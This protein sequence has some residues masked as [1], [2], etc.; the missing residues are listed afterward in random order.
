[1]RTQ[2]EYRREVVERSDVVA[3][4]NLLGDDGWQLVHAEPVTIKLYKDRSVFKLE[5]FLMREKE[6]HIDPD[7]VLG[8]GSAGDPI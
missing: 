2:Y 8:V 1:M 7:E 4:L 3:F 6:E 5:C